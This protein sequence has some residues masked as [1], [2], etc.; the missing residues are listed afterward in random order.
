[1]P[2]NV[3]EEFN[4]AAPDSQIAVQSPDKPNE[5]IIVISP[6]SQGIF[7][8]NPDTILLEEG[9]IA[10]Q[11]MV[12][13]NPTVARCI[14]A[15]KNAILGM[16]ITFEAAIAD[17][18]AEIQKAKDVSAMFDAMDGTLSDLTKSL[19]DAMIDG[20]Q[21]NEPVW[22]P[23]K[24]STGTLKGKLGFWK[25]KQ[26]P[27]P[28]INFK[29]DEYRNV[30]KISASQALGESYLSAG[31][32]AEYDPEFFWHLIWDKKAENPYGRSILRPLYF[33]H[34]I[35]K[36]GIKQAATAL[37]RFGTPVKLVRLDQ[38]KF[39]AFMHKMHPDLEGDESG[40]RGAVANQVERIQSDMEKMSKTNLITGY[41]F[42]EVTIL[43]SAHISEKLFASQQSMVKA[44]I[45]ETILGATLN[46]SAP[47]TS[48]GARALGE[49]H[50]R[51]TETITQADVIWIEAAYNDNIRSPIKMFC[52]I[53][54]FD[55]SNG[56]PKLRLNTPWKESIQDSV[57]R[58]ETALTLD[59][60]VAK[61]YAQNLLKIPS[62][63]DG[64][65]ALSP[66]PA[67]AEPDFTPVAGS[68]E[69]VLSST[70]ASYRAK[71]SKYNP[72]P[73]REAY[74]D[75]M[76][77]DI[78]P[79]YVNEMNELKQLISDQV[80]SSVEET[81]MKVLTRISLNVTGTQNKP[82]WLTDMFWSVLLISDLNGRLY[83]QQWF[84]ELTP[85]RVAMIDTREA[86]P[87]TLSTH[88]EVYQFFK[89]LTPLTKKDFMALESQYRFQAI[90]YAGIEEAAVV[91]D[92][93]LILL[94]T[95]QNGKGIE[96]F[97][98]QLAQGFIK[99]T[100]TAYGDASKAG[101]EIT[102]AHAE[103]I[104]RTNM[105]K[106]YSGGEQV[107]HEQ[108][109]DDGSLIAYTYRFTDDGRQRKTHEDLGGKT[110]AAGDPL[111]K[112]PPLDFSCRCYLEVVLKGEVVELTDRALMARL[113]SKVGFDV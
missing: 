67:P 26:K 64:E 47:E 49:V 73:Q 52:D 5:L 108:A 104:F 46:T 87:T 75:K 72:I 74:L 78:T 88:D 42:L 112:R 40:F 61:G 19:L 79:K 96:Y 56:Y 13:Q 11:E 34:Y 28:L 100:G 105:M 76:M 12:E 6:I 33:Y 89:G 55:N 101:Q 3:K 37:D 1:M 16:D 38:E 97:N 109:E 53:N 98:E 63:E 31:L 2:I 111:L 24:Y 71:A 86:F 57:Y 69:A 44:L 50:E 30:V 15:R 45:T 102:L 43:E 10:Y 58:V 27:S 8:Q 95:L 60:P 39:I 35:A 20:F 99:Y 36:E 82:G 59:I 41:D 51:A 25:I 77:E 83:P 91:K 62:L 48:T 29:Q 32:R 106:A 68:A 81:D 23:E 21:V 7:P 93:Q 65:E 4:R 22:M 90:T 17:H 70:G 80:G 84:E 92:V 18:P 66:T 94:D 110:M 103:T 9:I 85:A 107:I 113:L 14:T 54:Y